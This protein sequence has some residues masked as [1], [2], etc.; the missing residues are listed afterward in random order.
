[1]KMIDREPTIPGRPDL[2]AEWDKL[3]GQ[4]FNAIEIRR[5]L[6]IDD[7]AEKPNGSVTTPVRR[8]RKGVGSHRG[9]R[10]LMAA[11]AGRIPEHVRAEIERVPDPLSPEEQV[12]AE[13]GS[14]AAMVWIEEQKQNS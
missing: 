13:A 2:D 9:S 14:L 8:F 3:D 6:G 11:D 4:G 5:R 1:M 12:A 10:A 7:I